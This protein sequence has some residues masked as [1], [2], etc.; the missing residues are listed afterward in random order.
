MR[1]AGGGGGRKGPRWLGSSRPHPDLAAMDAE[2]LNLQ[3]L[4]FNEKLLSLKIR[5][6]STCGAGRGEGGRG[7]RTARAPADALPSPRSHL[8]PDPAGGSAFNRQGAA[9]LFPQGT[10]GKPL[11]HASQQPRRLSS[12]THPRVH[13]PQTPTLTL[14]TIKQLDLLLL[15]MELAAQRLGF[16]TTVVRPPARPLPIAKEG[17]AAPALTSLRPQFKRELRKLGI[18]RWPGR[19]MKV[20]GRRFCGP[21][22]GPARV[23]LQCAAS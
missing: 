21:V 16:G 9:E 18:K 22:L 5:E 6:E 1:L 11:G 7:A 3:P 12:L 10:A 19:T 14:E 2:A 4:P 23:P 8:R 20:R 13:A 17:A 15:P